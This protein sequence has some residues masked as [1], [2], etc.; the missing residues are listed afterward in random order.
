MVEPCKV[1]LFYRTYQSQRQDM[2]LVHIG[3]IL[4]LSRIPLLYWVFLNE[5]GSLGTVEMCLHLQEIAKVF[6]KEY[7]MDF[8]KKLPPVYEFLL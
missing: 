7:K 8:S 4:F 3:T 6:L 2:I 1:I 5:R